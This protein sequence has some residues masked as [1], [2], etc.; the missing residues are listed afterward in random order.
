VDDIIN[1]KTKLSTLSIP[2][3]QKLSGKLSLRTDSG[4]DPKAD[5]NGE[6]E[7]ARSEMVIIN[8]SYKYCNFRNLKNLFIQEFI[9]KL[10]SLI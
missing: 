6:K 2:L 5:E 9:N 7:M 1:P 8:L 10:M 4:T 3:E